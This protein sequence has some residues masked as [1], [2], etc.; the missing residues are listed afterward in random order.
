MTASKPTAR[1]VATSALSQADIQKHDAALRLSRLICQTDQRGRATDLVFGVIRNRDILDSVLKQIG[2]VHKDRTDKR[3]MTILQIAAYE[4]IY[5]PATP[6]YAI[7]NEAVEMAARVSKKAAGFVNAVLRNFGRAIINR[8]ASLADWP[9]RRTIPADTSTGCQMN[10]DIFP[11]IQRNQA[12]FVAEAFCLPVW[13]IQEWLDDYGNDKTL[14]ICFACNR[15]PSVVIWPN[16]LKTTA[17]QLHDNLGKQDKLGIV[18]SPD[19]QSLKLNYSGDIS[20]LDAFREGLFFVQDV[21]SASAISLLPVDKGM[22][23]LDLCSAPGTKTACLAGRLDNTGTIYAADAD[24]AR[25]DKVLQNCSRLGIKNVVIIEPDGLHPFLSNH[26][27][28]DAVIC[29]VPCSNTGVLARRVEVRHRLTTQSILSLTQTQRSI[30]QQAQ[31]VCRPGGYI[32]YSTCSIQR[33]ENQQI[34]RW[35]LEQYPSMRL[36]KEQITLPAVETPY[37]FDHDGGY[38]ALLQK[39]E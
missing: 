8:S 37:S 34:I 4:L 10:Y 15:H 1:Q 13:L 20:Q 33:S 38:A 9:N 5:V 35:F 22:K 17:S 31:A 28:M 19:G 12:Q 3:I 14:S 18:L 39:Q 32:L 29:D 2:N 24:K 36:V 26:T 21:S 6:D 16:L 23:I 30:L 27:Q 7:V 25:L 11:D